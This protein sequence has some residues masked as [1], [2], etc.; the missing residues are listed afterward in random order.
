MRIYTKTGDR[1]KT[2]LYGG[3]RVPK[4]DIRVDAYG[5]VDELNSL[6]GVT[7]SKIKDKKISDFL[8][9]IQS[10]LFLIGSNLAGAKT[11]LS[12]IPVRISEMEKMIDWA[13]AQLPTLKNFILP[14]GVESATFLFY[15]RAV[16]RRCERA[17]VELNQKEAVDP[18]LLIYINRLSDLLFEM[19]RFLNF[20]KG[21]K[22]TI[23]KRNSVHRLQ[24]YA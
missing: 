24:R 5:T 10:D 22:E 21:I 23:W 9:R 19:A 7:L 20:K 18:K 1:G 14:S 4:D 8:G 16:A 13:D 11:D 12:T 2:S 15:A 17:I 6:L 3:K